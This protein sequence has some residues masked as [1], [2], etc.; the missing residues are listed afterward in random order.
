M[1]GMTCINKTLYTADQIA[2]IYAGRVS[3][4]LPKK[5]KCVVISL[6][7]QQLERITLWHEKSKTTNKKLYCVLLFMKTSDKEKILCLP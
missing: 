7:N 4:E 1:I 5:G 3:F 2:K 6:P